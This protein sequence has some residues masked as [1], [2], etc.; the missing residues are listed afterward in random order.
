MSLSFSRMWSVQWRVDQAQL[1]WLDA[2]NG[3]FRAI[4]RRAVFGAVR[5]LQDGGGLE[6]GTVGYSESGYP[7]TPN[8]WALC[9][10][11]KRP[12]TRPTDCAGTGVSDYGRFPIGAGLP[13]PAAHPPATSEKSSSTLLTKAWQRSSTSST[14]RRPGPRSAHSH[15]T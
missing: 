13:S 11:K 12:A 7:P 8:S 1:S 4:R 3:A 15:T 9:P 5:Q 14:G 10:T 6:R 2:N